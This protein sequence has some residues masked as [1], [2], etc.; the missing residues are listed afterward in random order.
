MSTKLNK[1]LI[2]NIF[3][4]EVNSIWGWRFVRGAKSKNSLWVFGYLPVDLAA[5]EKIANPS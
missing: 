1:S 5:I 2:D 3:R 4:I